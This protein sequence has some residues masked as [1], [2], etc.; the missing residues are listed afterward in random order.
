MLF[1][2]VGIEEH[3]L[4]HH[5]VC[6]LPATLGDV[7]RKF[8]GYPLRMEE[9][10]TFHTRPLELKYRGNLHNSRLKH[11]FGQGGNLLLDAI[12]NT[13]GKSPAATKHNGTI[14]DMTSLSR[15]RKPSA[16]S[17][18]LEHQCRALRT[19]SCHWAPKAADIN[20]SERTLS[21][22]AEDWGVIARHH[23]LDSFLSRGRPSQ[24]LDLLLKAVFG[25]RARCGSKFLVQ[26]L[27]HS[28]PSNIE[29]TRSWS[30]LVWE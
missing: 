3:E 1:P 7:L 14:S 15:W 16:A 18:D 10:S 29:K 8:Y 11:A 19:I 6:A 27:D 2:F 9:G 21:G 23:D 4:P 28:S 24:S 17:A 20:D 5:T 13:H 22:A 25:S 12:L 30:H 26:H